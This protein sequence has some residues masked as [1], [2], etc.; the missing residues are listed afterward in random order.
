VKKTRG[1]MIAIHARTREHLADLRTKLAAE[2]RKV[3]VLERII[4]CQAALNFH[5]IQSD[6]RM[7]ELTKAKRA[8]ERLTRKDAA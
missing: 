2:Q 6:Y 3:R 8:F 7:R 1:R 4:E 5:P